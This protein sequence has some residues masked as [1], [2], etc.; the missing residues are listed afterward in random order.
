MRSE[1]LILW[2]S[3]SS[4]SSYLWA[5]AV[6]VVPPGLSSF[7]PSLLVWL[8]N[9]YLSFTAPFKVSFFILK[10]ATSIP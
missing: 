7:L 8:T 3:V 1:I 6:Q 2:I 9:S 10:K 5:C 4:V